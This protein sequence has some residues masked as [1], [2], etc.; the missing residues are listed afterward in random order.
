MDNK[1]K[2]NDYIVIIALLIYFVIL[3]V[4]GAFLLM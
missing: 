3:A 2:N 4:L 1:E